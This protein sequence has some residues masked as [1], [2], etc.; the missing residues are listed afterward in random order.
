MSFR[1]ILCPIDFSAGSRKAMVLAA[2]LAKIHGSELVVAHS[3]FLPPGS[4]AGEFVYPVELVKGQ[5][6][7]NDRALALAV[8]EVRSLGVPRVSS[9]MS[10]GEPWVKIVELAQADPEIDLIVIGTHGRTGIGRMFLGSVTEMVVRHAPCSVLAIPRDGECPPFERILCP[11]D[12]SESSRLALDL[13]L[14]LEP[15]PDR[16]VTLL[17]IIEPPRIYAGESGIDVHPGLGG[18]SQKLLETWGAAAI[19]KQPAKL[20]A[21]VRIGRPGTQVLA[22]L[23]EEKA[24]DLVAVGSHGRTG[25]Q[26]MFLGSVAERVVRHAARPVLVARSRR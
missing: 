12:F 1:K 2:R 11:V 14:E 22:V 26:R 25:L 18:G 20:T 16:T 7:D 5:V 4:V 9:R 3:W 17:H 10:D 24:F 13:A 19:A 15:V 21:F 8:E 6:E 23:G